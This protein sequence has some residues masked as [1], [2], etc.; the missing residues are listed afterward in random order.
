MRLGWWK[1]FSKD[2]NAYI[3]ALLGIKLF[4]VVPSEMCDERTASKL[5]ATD[6]AKRNNLGPENLI[7]CAQL[8]QYWRFASS[9]RSPTTNRP[10][11]S[12]PGFLLNADS[13]DERSIDEE[14]LFNHTDPYGIK[15]YED[16]EEGEDE[17]DSAPPP[18]VIRQANMPTLE[19][20]T[21]IDL[22][23]PKLVLRFA[24]DQG[25]LAPE[26]PLVPTA[27]KTTSGA[28]WTEADASWDADSW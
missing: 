8:N 9:F 25:K 14:A 1:S 11:P 18:L 16:M 7:R 23:A 22:N 24:P 6:T 15:D 13:L 4:S 26:E 17:T 27:K 20:E 3:L 12:S 5:T 28:K 10:I 2:S 21:Y 19:I